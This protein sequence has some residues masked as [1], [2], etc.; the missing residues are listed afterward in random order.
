[1]HYTI[2]CMIMFFCPYVVFA[3]ETE[4]PVDITV[5]E[6]EISEL[7]IESAA[8]SAHHKILH[9]HN[10]G[11]NVQKISI[12][13]EDEQ[14]Q[15]AE[16]AVAQSLVSL[17]RFHTTTLADEYREILEENDYDINAFCKKNI[18]VAKEWCDGEISASVEIA[19]QSTVDV[20]VTFYFDDDETDHRAYMIFKNDSNAERDEI[21]RVLVTYHVPDKNIVQMKLQSFNL[22]KE[23]P[24]GDFGMW[25]R[26]GMRDDYIA[27]IGSENNGT[28]NVQYTYF[29]EVESLWIG[30]KLFFSGENDSVTGSAMQS[31]RVH[32]TMPRF[33]KMRITGGISYIDQN[34]KKIEHRSDP[35]HLIVWPVHFVII[36]SLGSCFC[37][38]CVLLYKYIRK[39]MFG[40]R[41]NKKNNTQFTG[42]YIVQDT[43]NIISIA[44][45]FGV[46]WK[47]LAE[48]NKID[49]PYIL[50]SGETISVP[51]PQTPVVESV[52]ED[53][54]EQNALEQNHVEQ[55]DIGM[56]SNEPVMQKMPTIAEQRGEMKY[57][58][59]HDVQSI[60]N[61]M[62]HIEKK[63]P[64][65]MPGQGHG[66]VKR[67]VTF[68]APQS[69]LAQPASEP[70]T[71][72]IDIEW[73]R[74]DEEAYNEEMEFQRKSV[75][76]RLIIVIVVGVCAIG[77][78]IVW[79]VMQ[80]MQ[81]DAEKKISVE[82]LIE[83]N[84]PVKNDENVEE[85]S[86]E[87]VVQD[88]VSDE[89]SDDT[90]NSDEDQDVDEEK[91]NEQETQVTA[92]QK[93]PSEI[94][95]QVLNAGAATGAAGAV[96]TEIKNKGYK[97]NSAQNAQGSYEDVM[98]YHTSE[99]KDA[100]DALA[101]IVDAKYG[102]Q[103]KEESADVTGKY[104]ADIVIV[105]GA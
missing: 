78:F 101:Q 42:T 75:N 2:L 14:E 68:A 32:V 3:V 1:M 86:S 30:E 45:M 76:K 77:G 81:H 54:Q 52:Q 59:Q 100:V 94:T 19:P 85:S 43:D 10:G 74:D 64:S 7:Y 13:M 27:H 22:E 8:G 69:M 50:I 53:V 47:E 103:K 57:M 60:K 71:R 88:N 39:N 29:T 35:I 36:L 18:D 102:T 37:G 62:P 92:V 83:E 48:Y 84:A 9:I 33:G 34:Q 44:Q 89:H 24:F 90:A 11:E 67:K 70:T 26:S 93:T 25:L 28:E 80:W 17:T 49:A 97:I 15:R 58:P 56:K 38:I 40:F 12:S 91:S 20:P 87:D 46:P 31:D 66:P 82:T 104:K 16:N 23:F 61:E 72:A 95:V 98:I 99:M 6:Q 79:G 73:M 21:Q 96:S 63:E 55:E 41:K 5:D 51:G 4:R 65:I 105:L